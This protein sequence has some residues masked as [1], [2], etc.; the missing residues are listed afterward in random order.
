MTGAVALCGAF[1]IGRARNIRPWLIGYLVPVFGLFVFITAGPGASPT[2][3]VWLYL[4]LVIS[5]PLLGRRIGFAV[6]LPCVIYVCADVVIR[7]APLDS[8]GDWVNLMNP[9]FCG[10]MLLLF[11][12]FY[13]SMRAEDQARLAALAQTDALTGLANRNSFRTALDRAINDSERRQAQ[14]TLVLADI[15]RFKRVNDSYGHDAGDQV[16]QHIAQCLSGR[17]RSTDSVGRLGGE[18]FGLILCDID[19]LSAHKLTQELLETIAHREIAYGEYQLQVTATFGIAHWPNDAR[20][21]N[22]LYQ[23][24]DRRLYAGKHFGRNT[25]VAEDAGF[26]FVPPLQAAEYPGPIN[27]NGEPG[28]I[29]I[30]M[31]ETH[32]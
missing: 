23:E 24:A 16:L 2:A 12:H 11:M 25:I 9:I 5:Y 30:L 7:L 13:E 3:F 17:V 32:R 27:R 29:A 15:D 20:S 26:H 31:E 6:A 28:S 14:F 1:T 19:A 18:E 4:L 10:V 8:V 22:D 21:A